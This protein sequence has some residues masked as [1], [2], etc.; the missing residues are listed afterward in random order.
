MNTN[1]RKTIYVINMSELLYPSYSQ[2]LNKGVIQTIIQSDAD[3]AMLYGGHNKL[4]LTSLKIDD[5]LVKDINNIF[6]YKNSISLSPQ[7]PSYSLSKDVIEQEEF[8][9]RIQ[10]WIG[11]TSPVYLIP[12]GASK[13]FFE[14]ADF[15][16]KKLPHVQFEL[17]ESVERRD[18]FIRDY[19]DSKSGFKE[20]WNRSAKEIKTPFGFTC[21]DFE[22]VEEAALY[23]YNHAID[24]LIKKDTGVA[25]F[26]IE[27][28]DIFKYK[29]R[30]HLLRELKKKCSD[31]L[32]WGMDKIIVEELIPISPK[33]LGGSPSIEYKISKGKAHYEYFCP[34]ILTSD[35]NFL[36]IE[37]SKESERNNFFE[38]IAR[39]SRLFANEIAHI[40]Y[41]GVF[42]VDFVI[43]QDNQTYA[44]ESNTRRTGGTH[45]WEA[46][47][48]LLGKDRLGNYI[49]FSND[50]YDVPSVYK[51][52]SKVRQKLLDLFYGTF[53]THEG[54]IVTRASGLRF[55][56][57]GYLCIARSK[58]RLICLNQEITKRFH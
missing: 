18:L 35:G 5:V 37:I 24:F 22:Q 2:N 4:V 31:R 15:L 38:K 16:K 33:I 3:R 7:N 56:K 57:L 28:F 17:S 21:K 26:G 48:Y 44:V 29:T 39:D 46:A 14:M 50:S 13:E 40:G 34:Q 11:K 9:D 43:S 12:Y 36:G 30:D 42:D 32:I 19:L 23:F 41:M 27:R 8:F 49:L 1:S 6:G 25:G 54:I 53:G 10:K 51:N 58:K 45:V 47:N 20:I 55:G 52:Y